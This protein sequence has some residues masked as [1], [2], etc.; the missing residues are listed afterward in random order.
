MPLSVL[1]SID[2]GRPMRADPWTL[3]AFFQRRS[4]WFAWY[5]NLRMTPKIVLPVTIVLV[6][7]LAS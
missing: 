4:L 7:S 6:L 1:S 2:A 3:C 5:R